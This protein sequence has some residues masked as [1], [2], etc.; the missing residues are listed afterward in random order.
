[1]PPV[2]LQHV[3]VQVPP[4][5]LDACVQFYEGLLGLRQIPNLAGVAWFEIGDTGDHVHLLEGPGAQSSSG[6]LAMQVV[7]LEPVL[8]RLREA[9][10]P[11][12]PGSNIWGAPRWFVRDPAG[13][14]VE[15]FE[16]PP[17]ETAG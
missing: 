2:R 15:L 3:S 16:T 8:A 12:R 14:L 9:G 4:G 10:H 5:Q 6:H 17:P 7:P 11:P 1:M 13:N